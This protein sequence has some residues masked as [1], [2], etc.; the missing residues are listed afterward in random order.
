MT[1]Y[2]I[3]RLERDVEALKAE[4][5]KLA[6]AFASLA[7]EIDDMKHPPAPG[8]GSEPHVDG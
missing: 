7:Q 5:V 1:E 3:V 4:T 6:M 2:D 8:V